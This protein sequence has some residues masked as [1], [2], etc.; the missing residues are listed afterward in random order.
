MTIGIWAILGGLC[1]PAIAQDF[2]DLEDF[3][4]DEPADPPE[5]PKDDD[6]KTSSEEE[7]EPAP[8]PPIDDDEILDDEEILD[9]ED[10]EGP[11]IDLLE[12]DPD[13]QVEGDD[14]TEATFRDTLSRSERLAPDAA[15]QEWEA[16]LEKYPK[17]LYR[18]QIEEQIELLFDRLYAEGRESP[19][20]E[21]GVVDAMRQEIEFSQ[22]L[23]LDNINPRTRLQLALTFGPPTYLD[24]TADFEAALSRRFSLHGGVRRRFSGFGIE[25]G[26]RYALVKSAK[27][28]TLVTVSF[29]TR[30]TINPLYPSFRPVLGFGQK[31]GDSFQ[32]QLQVGSDLDLRQVDGVELQAR[33]TGGAQVQWAASDRVSVFAETFLLFKPQPADGSFEGGLFSFNV[34]SVGLTFFPA[35]N[36]KNPDERNVEAKIGGSVPVAQ[37]YYRYYLGSLNGQFNYFL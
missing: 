4:F 19:E 30:L 35:V 1:S 34:V 16:Y 15:I 18:Q 10:E 26:P 29:D 23:L 12:D 13:E 37:R 31:L 6:E 8:E 28:D 7:E 17:T 32:F 11:E 24:L 5:K 21:G 25:F 20:E 36:A 33:V 14:D 2:D 27:T 3:E 9:F 22:G